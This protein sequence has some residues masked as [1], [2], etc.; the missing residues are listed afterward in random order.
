MASIT[1]RS[2]KNGDTYKICVSAGRDSKDGQIRHYMTWKPPQG[3]TARKVEKEL[4]R[5]AVEF[6]QK[7]LD[8]FQADNRQTFAEYAQYVVDLKAPE[9]KEN[10]LNQSR[11]LLVRINTEIGRM[12]LRDIKPRHLNEFYKKLTEPGANQRRASY[13]P[14]VDFDALRN[15]K[16][17]KDF[18]AQCGIGIVEYAR[19]R[20]GYGVTEKT[21]KLIEKNL[22]ATGLFRKIDTP[23]PLS[24]ETIHRVHSLIS[25]VFS[26]AEKEMIIDFNPAKR[27][28]VPSTRKK[29][30][31]Y[32][33]PD[34]VAAVIKALETEPIWFRTMIM[35]FVTTGCRRGEILGLKWDK[36]GFDT[37]RIKIDNNIQYLPKVGIF[38]ESPKTGRE[39][40]IIVPQSTI[41]MLK[42]W[43]QFQADC[44]DTPADYVFC[45]FDT[46]KPLTPNTV[47]AALQR[48]CARHGLRHIHPHMF[49]H[50]AASI[51][52]S[53]GVDV[54]TVSKMLGHAT[55]TTTLDIYGHVIL[56]AESR[57]ADCITEKLTE[58]STK[59]NAKTKKSV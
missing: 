16:M 7:I 38:E 25:T 56:E 52:I 29:Q 22:N 15:G 21:A 1:K 9:Y 43:R 48:F 31:D 53:S 51:L 34:E 28:N 11:R 47:N 33:Q 23:A 59:S 55:T 41:D 50:T 30:A 14:A 32:L 4:N 20:K 18:A 39:R 49:R 5:V 26:Q 8:G 12:K 37:R 3:M 35:L 10:T 58:I 54:L 45:R 24:S 27:A 17:K 46:G 44:M 13:I 57:A 6:E 36:I 2:G 40:F 42:E 19:I